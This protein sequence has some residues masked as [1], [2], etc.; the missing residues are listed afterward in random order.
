MAELAVVIVLLGLVAMI[1][2]T[3]TMMVS[4]TQKNYRIDSKGQTELV[5][6]ETAFKDWLAPYDSAEWKLIIN[7][8]SIEVTKD[9]MSAMYLIEFNNGTLS[10]YP[11]TENETKSI[12]FDSITDI[13]FSRNNDI[14]CCTATIEN[15]QHK[16]LYTMRTF[17]TE[18]SAGDI[19]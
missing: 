19:E 7:K 13:T 2:T 11:T 12:K 16:I 4:R 9:T 6:L 15:Y 14:I 5:R 10:F 1:A 3:I 8:N 17:E 18:T